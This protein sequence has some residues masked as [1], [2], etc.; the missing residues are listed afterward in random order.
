MPVP[1]SVGPRM[2][3]RYHWISARTTVGE[4]PAKGIPGNPRTIMRRTWGVN[5]ERREQR[6]REG[7]L[8]S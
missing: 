7:V 5:E 2:S 8:G 6:Q 3:D 1:V 4:T